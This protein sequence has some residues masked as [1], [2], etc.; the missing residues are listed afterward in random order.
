MGVKKF[1]TDVIHTAGFL[2]SC[3]ISNLP[4]FALERVGAQRKRNPNKAMKAAILM[5]FL[6]I[7][8]S[9]KSWARLAEE[10]DE[11]RNEW[12]VNPSFSSKACYKSKRLFY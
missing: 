4:G 12:D 8:A 2:T 7:G 10:W 9:F 6:C 3:R 11:K 5:N 1:H